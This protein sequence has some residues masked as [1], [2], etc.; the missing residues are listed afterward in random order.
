MSTASTDSAATRGALAAT[1]SFLLWGI[2][3][4]YWKQIQSVSAFELIAHRIAWSLL[5]LLAVLAWQKSFASLQMAFRD[6]RVFASTLLSGLVLAVNWT[7]YVWAVNS[8]HVIE[9]SLGYF[10]T[11][12]CNV[13]LG[14]VFFHE[15]LRSLQWTAIALAVAGVAVLLFKAGHIPWIA[16]S[17]AV[18]WALYGILKKKSALGSIAGLTVETMLLFP[19]AA[20]L[21]LWRFHAGESAYE[22]PDLRLHLLIIGLGVTTTIPL[23]LFSYGARRLRLATLG[24]LQYI[25]PSVQFLLGLLVYHEPFDTARLHACLLIWAGLLIYTADSFWTQRRKFWPASEAA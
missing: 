23:V 2:M 13:A 15:R 6:A 20:A 24:L 19:L 12:L 8:G 5:L 25:A 16:L 22:Q 11:P 17:L 10:L 7:I 3:P 21:L 18:S 9:S 1:A 14:F 4:L